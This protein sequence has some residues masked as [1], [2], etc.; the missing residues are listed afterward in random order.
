MSDMDRPSRDD[1]PI[2]R[3]RHGQQTFRISPEA[4]DQHLRAIAGALET[5]TP[6]RS[7]RALAA[8]AAAILTGLPAAA[9]AS[10][11]AVPGDVLYPVKRTAE[12]AWSLVDPDIAVRHRLEELEELRR[13][14]G[15]PERFEALLDEARREAKELDDDELRSEVE[16]ALE[17]IERDRRDGDDHDE[18]GDD[19]SSGS[20]TASTMKPDDDDSSSTI[21]TTDAD[22]ESS[23][24]STTDADDDSSGSG[25]SATSTT[26]PDDGGGSS[27]TSTTKPEDDS[28][29]SGASTTSTTEVD[30]DSP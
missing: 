13:R 30:D 19:D 24:T 20:S 11:G 23:T 28:S 18:D 26:R 22:D 14:D 12:A 27:T 6:G 7:R 4:R 3:L 17:R 8:W 10:Q 15:D 21:S 1:D 29:G 9:V 2:D 16:D 5:A 25:S